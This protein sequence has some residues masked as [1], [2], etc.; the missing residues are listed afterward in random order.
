MGHLIVHVLSLLNTQPRCCGIACM[1]THPI[2]IAWKPPS[3]KHNAETLAV[4]QQHRAPWKLVCRKAHHTACTQHPLL[5]LHC[6]CWHS[7]YLCCLNKA[8]R[9]PQCNPHMPS[10]MFTLDHTSQR[11]TTQQLLHWLLLLIA[12]GLA[13]HLTSVCCPGKPTH[14]SS[15]CNSSHCN[16]SHCDS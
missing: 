1:Y 8:T 14:R 3:V 4:R 12:P 13:M 11:T 7:G 5:S 6:A 16:S 10:Q 2:P 9:P 15:H